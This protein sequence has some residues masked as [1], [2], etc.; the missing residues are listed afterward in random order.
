M[1]SSPWNNLRVLVT[2]H[3]GFKGG[4]LTLKLASLGASVCGYSLSPVIEPNLF[5]AARIADICRSEI[6]DVRDPVRFGAVVADFK[7]ELVFHMAAQALVRVSYHDPIDTYSTNVMGLVT[8][9]EVLRHSSSVQHVINVTSDKCYE[10]NGWLWGY[11]ESDPMGGFDPYSSSKGCAELITSSWRRSFFSKAG[12]SLSSVR[13]GNVIGGGDW[14]LDRLIPDFV[15]SIDAG[16]EL[17]IRSPRSTRPWQHVLEPLSG[18]LL[19]AERLMT[20]GPHFADGWNF[21]PDVN[22]VRDVE[23][24]ASLMCRLWG[25]PAKMRVIEDNS[26]HEASNLVLD[27]S[28]AVFGLGWKPVWGVDTAIERVVSWHKRYLSGA[29]AYSLCIGDIEAHENDLSAARGLLI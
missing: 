27:S 7:P 26:L 8:V 10:N 15:R 12:I 20:G 17:T 19:L 18:Y 21:G 13:A 9:L 2:G 4:W 22:S 24:I 16:R 3:T 14:S 23:A 28:K 6:G 11:R 25:E 29:N 5:V 1:S